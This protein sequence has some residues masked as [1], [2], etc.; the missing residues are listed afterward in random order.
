[1]K[2]KNIHNYTHQELID[3][4]TQAKA[5]MQFK[6]LEEVDIT[7]A[8][9]QEELEDEQHYYEVYQSFLTIEED[10]TVEEALEMQI[11]T[12][13]VVKEYKTKRGLIQ[14]FLND[15]DVNGEYYRIHT[16]L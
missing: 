10:T 7:L 6:G 4:I 13:K 9:Y 16:Q 5:Y 15:K 14:A 8:N 12:E 1:M 2:L 3:I 11:D